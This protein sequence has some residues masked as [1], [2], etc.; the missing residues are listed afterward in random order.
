MKYGFQ[1]SQVYLRKVFRLRRVVL[2]NFKKASIGRF[3]ESGVVL[4]ARKVKMDK[5]R[6]FLFCLYFSN[7]QIYVILNSYTV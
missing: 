5:N 3:D 2:C 4:G 1:N 7:G 6:S